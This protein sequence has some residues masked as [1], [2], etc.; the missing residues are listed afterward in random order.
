MSNVKAPRAWDDA[1]DKEFYTPEEIA[2]SDMRA[3]IITAM[4][5]AREEM[6]LSQRQLEELSG[7]RQPQI[8][9]MERGNADPQLGTLLRVLNAMGKTLAIVPL[10]DRQ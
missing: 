6:G 10:A 2:E 4:I 7:V 9:R 5:Q 1:F 8:A 3:G